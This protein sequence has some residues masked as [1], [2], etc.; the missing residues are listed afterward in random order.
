MTQLE[1]SSTGTSPF[2]FPRFWL[3]SA[4][5]RS[6]FPCFQRPDI[7]TIPLNQA[8]VT[9]STLLKSRISVLLIE[10]SIAIAI[11]IVLQTL[12]GEKLTL[13]WIWHYSNRSILAVSKQTL[14]GTVF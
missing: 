8:L 6:P 3:V 13:A 10:I 14:K 2:S 7:R 4:L 11:G 12:W 9:L 1:P 5:V